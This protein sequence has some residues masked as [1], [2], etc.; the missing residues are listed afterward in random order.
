[1]K[2]RNMKSFLLKEFPK[3]Y[4]NAS[5]ELHF[6]DPFQLTVSVMLSAQCTDKKVNEITPVLFAKYPSFQ[7]LSKARISAL[8]RII[9]PINYYKSKAKNLLGM[10]N[11]VMHAFNGQLPTDF[12]ELVSLAGVGQ[13]TANVIL[14]E[15]G[16]EETFPVDTHVFRVSKRLGLAGG[17]NREIVEEELKELFPSQY[18][19]NLHHWLILHGRR[20]CKAPRPKCHECSLASRCPSAE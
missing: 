2:A 5:S 8:E 15:L 1:M 11:R 16:V 12:D 20:V 10:A 4:P 19:R 14:T 7:A 13:K 9:K 17:K 6:K 18:W 3:L